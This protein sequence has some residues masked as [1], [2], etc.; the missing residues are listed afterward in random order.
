M[1]ENEKLGKLKRLGFTKREGEKGRKESAL[2]QLAPVAEITPEI[3][4][5]IS[6]LVEAN[7]DIK[8]LTENLEVMQVV[9]G[10][11][12]FADIVE[13][14]VDEK[15]DTEKTKEVVKAICKNVNTRAR[16]SQNLATYLGKILAKFED[17]EVVDPDVSDDEEEPESEE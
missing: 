3:D 12:E 15:L 7:D 10:S 13:M 17:A 6:G 4:E 11:K 16:E 14:A 5:L 2:N 9:A 1:P 8:E